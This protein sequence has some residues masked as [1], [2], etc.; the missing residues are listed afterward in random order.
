MRQCIREKWDNFVPQ[1]FR[2][3]CLCHPLLI[4]RFGVTIDL[5]QGLVTCYRTDFEFGCTGLGE[6]GGS[7]FAQAME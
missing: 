6:A 3:S 1:K 4:G 5:V 2:Y 7:S